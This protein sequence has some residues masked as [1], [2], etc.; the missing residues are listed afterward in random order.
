LIIYTSAL[1][2]LEESLG[3]GEIDLFFIHSCLF[4]LY[5]CLFS[6]HNNKHTDHE[7]VAEVHNSLGL[8]YIDLANL[9]KVFEQQT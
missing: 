2:I 5:S 9:A 6:F 4:F 8:L 7:E 1:E 3:I